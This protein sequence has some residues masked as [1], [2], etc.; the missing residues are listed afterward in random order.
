MNHGCYFEVT[1]DDDDDDLRAIIDDSDVGSDIKVIMVHCMR[2]EC[3]NN[4]E[5]VTLNHE[6]FKVKTIIGSRTAC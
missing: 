4:V 6:E 5:T 1:D 3:V 2:I